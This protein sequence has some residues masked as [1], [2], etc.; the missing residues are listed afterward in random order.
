MKSHHQPVVYSRP[1][2]GAEIRLEEQL[3]L[4][5]NREE[6]TSEPLCTLLTYFQDADQKQAEGAQMPP[7]LHF[8]SDA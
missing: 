3:L 8:F 7:S 1:D 5:M 6:L 2:N 4:L